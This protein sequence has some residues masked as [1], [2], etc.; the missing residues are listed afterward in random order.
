M[1]DPKIERQERGDLTL[2]LGTDGSGKSTFL[3]ELQKRRDFSILEPTSTK[4]AQAFKRNS[5]NS[6]VDEALVDC[7][8]EIY[9]K[10]NFEF[11]RLI[12]SKLESGN[13][14]ATTGNS[15]V[16]LVSHALMRSIVACKEKNVHML[17][18]RW[19][20]IDHARPNKLILVHA[21][22]QII[23]ERILDRQ[24]RGDLAERFWGF[25]SLHFL[26]LYQD[27]LH[28]TIEKISEAT[29]IKGIKLD[30]G[31]LSPHEMV[32]EYDRADRL[33]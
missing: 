14:I 19:L 28:Q 3:N 10:L 21:S 27:V 29:S 8:E 33:D 5:K 16:T 25:N 22:D 11:D 15:I 32:L 17:V 12:K 26:S 6:F 9:M 18:E 4:E 20:E 7:R 31:F 23:R 2:V 13:K 24:Q 30:S 1:H